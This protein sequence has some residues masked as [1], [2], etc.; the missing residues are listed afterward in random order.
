ML[1][2][3]CLLT[4]CGWQEIGSICWKSGWH[5]HFP[6]ANVGYGD[7]W[8]LS[9][10]KKFNIVSTFPMFMV[11]VTATGVLSPMRVAEDQRWMTKDLSVPC[12]STGSFGV[13]LYIVC[14]D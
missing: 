3:L 10:Q 12:S 1:V 14:Q 9:Q 2:S 13:W 6:H 7:G 5:I 8:E 11:T 4:V